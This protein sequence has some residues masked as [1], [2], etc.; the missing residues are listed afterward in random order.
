MLSWGDMPN[1]S[2]AAPA[3]LANSA[4]SPPRLSI[5]LEIEGRSVCLLGGGLRGTPWSNQSHWQTAQSGW[6][7]QR[8]V[9]C[10]CPTAAALPCHGAESHL[11]PTM[12]AGVSGGL[13]VLQVYGLSSSSAE[14]RSTRPRQPRSP[15]GPQSLSTTVGVGHWPVFR[16]ACASASLSLACASPGS[17]TRAAFWQEPTKSGE[18]EPSVSTA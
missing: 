8:A 5:G 14:G 11:F 1:R 6:E 10:D 18:P 9:V 16:Q 17:V 2:G 3:G 12:A 4:R 15:R 13:R 7:V